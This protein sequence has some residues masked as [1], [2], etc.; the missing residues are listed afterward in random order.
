MP[1]FN[2]FPNYEDKLKISY[3]YPSYQESGLYTAY[4]GELT[5]GD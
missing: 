1:P 3:I 4:Q 5:F 2:I